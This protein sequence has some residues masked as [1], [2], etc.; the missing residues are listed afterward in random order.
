MNGG[1][2]IKNVTFCDKRNP[3]FVIQRKNTRGIILRW[4][5]LWQQTI[6]S[7]TQDVTH[8]WTIHSKAGTPVLFYKFMTS[9]RIFD[10]KLSLSQYMMDRK[11]ITDKTGIPFFQKRV[12][13]EQKGEKDPL[14]D[15]HWKVCGFSALWINLL[16]SLTDHHLR[17][18]TYSYLQQYSCH[19][20]VLGRPL[21]VSLS[22]WCKYTVQPTLRKEM[23]WRRKIDQGKHTVRGSAS[24]RQRCCNGI[25]SRIQVSTLIEFN[26]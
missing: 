10:E 18:K 6:Q 23:H 4:A 7:L 15:G 24:I 19:F 13:E 8:S 21:Q 1:V 17:K 16:A 11:L 3:S 2:K 20:R 25:R 22:R 9:K 5:L 14:L 26:L 12:V